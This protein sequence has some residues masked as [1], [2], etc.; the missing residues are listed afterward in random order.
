MS[1]PIL[2]VKITLATHNGEEPPNTYTLKIRDAFVSHK[3]IVQIPW[4][5]CTV[6]RGIIK[7]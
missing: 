4:I 5:G 2:L 3:H 6:I 7:P 1:Q